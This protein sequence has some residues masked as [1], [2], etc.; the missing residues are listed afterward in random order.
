L[1]D[2]LLALNV[3]QGVLE[4]IT[5]EDHEWHA[6]TELVRTSASARGENTRKFVQHP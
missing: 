6:F 2:D 3:G 1:L 5:K 4:A